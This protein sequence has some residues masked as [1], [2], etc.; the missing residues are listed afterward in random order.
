MKKMVIKKII[1]ADSNVMYLH[2]HFQKKGGFAKMKKLI[3]KGNAKKVIYNSVM[4]W[5]IDQ[6]GVCNYNFPTSEH[7]K[8]FGVGIFFISF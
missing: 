1:L 5:N 3:V 4:N 6:V 8:R 7:L 2:E